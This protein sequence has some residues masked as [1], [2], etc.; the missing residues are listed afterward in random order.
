MSPFTKKPKQAL[1]FLKKKKQKDFYYS[2]PWAL[3]PSKPMAQH[4][5]VFCFFFSKKKCFLP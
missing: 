3:A 4:T 1:L 5:K 2:G